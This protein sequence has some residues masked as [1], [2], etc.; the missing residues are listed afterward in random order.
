MGDSTPPLRLSL[1][2]FD[3]FLRHVS[4]LDDHAFGSLA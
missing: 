4:R 2:S 3:W 1:E